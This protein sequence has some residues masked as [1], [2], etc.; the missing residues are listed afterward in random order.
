[1]TA[2]VFRMAKNNIIILLSSYKMLMI[3]IVACILPL[4]TIYQLKYIGLWNDLTIL[5]GL[6]YEFGL[7]TLHYLILIP[8]CI[9][10]VC[11]LVKP[12]LIDNFLFFRVGSRH[13]LFISKMISC[14]ITSVF[15]LIVLIMTG[16]I[17]LTFSFKIELRWGTSML[18]NQLQSGTLL[19]SSLFNLSPCLLILAQ[20]IMVLF[21]FTGSSLILYLFMETIKRKAFALVAVFIINFF[22]LVVAKSSTKFFVLV[23]A[24]NT[25]L[26]HADI[27]TK[28][29]VAFVIPL[30]Y[31]VVINIALVSANFMVIS[32]KDYLYEE[33]PEDE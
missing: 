26:A 6:Q 23:P 22:F 14:V 28:G 19:N 15:L 12:S 29:H 2:T 17:I 20:F 9:F 10:V 32:K 27:F 18:A 5:D 16:L 4:N 7:Y 31:W 30:I 24:A 13:N 1:M 8:L 25:F 11:D 33:A 21:S 3:L